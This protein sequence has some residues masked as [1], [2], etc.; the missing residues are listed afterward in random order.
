VQQQVAQCRG[1]QHAGV[2]DGDE[3]RHV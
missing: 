1:M 2:V 3:T